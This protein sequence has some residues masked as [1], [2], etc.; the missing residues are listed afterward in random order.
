MFGDGDGNIFVVGASIINMRCVML[1]NL[2]RC[3]SAR[4]NVLF[5]GLALFSSI[6]WGGRYYFR[7]S[8][9]GFVVRA[10]LGSS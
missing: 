3:H 6:L 10:C 8:L 4:R 9:G 7:Y 5:F 2:Y 1:L